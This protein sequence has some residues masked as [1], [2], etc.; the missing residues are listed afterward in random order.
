MLRIL[1]PWCSFFGVPLVISSNFMLTGTNLSYIQR[2][3]S[4]WSAG[5]T[6]VEF[7]TRC[8]DFYCWIQSEGEQMAKPA[9]R[10]HTLNST[11]EI[12]ASYTKLYV[13]VCVTWPLDS[14]EIPIT[15]FQ[16]RVLS[17]PSPRLCLI[18]IKVLLLDVFTHK[19]IRIVHPLITSL[20]DPQDHRVDATAS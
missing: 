4:T 19:E 11:V 13:S 7:S 17:L 18:R 6:Y 15:Q 3:G 12:L 9:C 10:G 16:S 5:S 2:P 8:Q 14:K 20:H 1:W